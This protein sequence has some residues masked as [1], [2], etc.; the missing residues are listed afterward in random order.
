MV[1]YTLFELGVFTVLTIGIVWIGHIVISHRK[2]LFSNGL[3]AMINMVKY[4]V[5]S[6]LTII[7]FP[8]V[9]VMWLIGKWWQ[10]L[11]NIIRKD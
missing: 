2:T 7:F 10:G 3:N 8:V 11:K 9:I 1:T 4:E 6:W 5:T